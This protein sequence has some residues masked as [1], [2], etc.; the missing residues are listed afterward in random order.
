MSSSELL[1]LLEKEATAERERV[2]GEAR[3]QADQMRAAAGAEARH[4]VEAQRQQQ[5]A[6]LRTSRVRAQ[7]TASLQAQA[8]LLETKDQLIADVFRR[9]EEALDQVVH[10]RARYTHILER[11]VAEGVQGFGGRAIIEAHPDDVDLV[12]AAVQRQKL[13][14]EVRGDAGVR[15]GVRLVSG[16]GRYV[17]LNMLASRLER[18]RPT[19]ASD[20]ARVLWG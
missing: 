4:G 20:I 6:M 7:S 18:A 3:A 16:D 5:E 9:A 13:D 14:A 12:R 8:L 19:L 10:D 15:G 1:S 11:L 17:V 2:L